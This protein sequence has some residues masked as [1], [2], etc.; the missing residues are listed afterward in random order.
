ML[1]EK[2]RHTYLISCNQN[3]EDNGFGF[4]FSEGE[5]IALLYLTETHQRIQPLVL[6]MFWVT[7]VMNCEAHIR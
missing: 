1:S 5:C 6:A 3:G 4:A 7:V 2:S